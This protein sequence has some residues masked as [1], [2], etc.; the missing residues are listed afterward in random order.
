[1]AQCVIAVSGSAYVL[2]SS[3]G[4]FHGQAFMLEMV[5]VVIDTCY[6][7]STNCPVANVGLFHTL[8]DWICKYTR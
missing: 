2:I 1:M 4:K 8:F 6:I 7:D 3:S 5:G